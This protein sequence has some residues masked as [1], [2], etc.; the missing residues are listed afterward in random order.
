MSAARAWVANR[1][2]AR[3][4]KVRMGEAPAGGEVGWGISYQNAGRGA[5]GRLEWTGPS[6]PVRHA[7]PARGVRLRRHPGRLPRGGRR[8]LR[9]AGRTVPAEH[10]G[11]RPGDRPGDP[12]PPAAQADGHHGLEAAAADPGVP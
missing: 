5:S 4:S 9:P 2:A 12:D 8:Y 1:A 6:E 10:R 3:A 11:D 7:V